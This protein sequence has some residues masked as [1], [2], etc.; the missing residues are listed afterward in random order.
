MLVIQRAIQGAG[1]K[2][3]KAARASSMACSARANSCARNSTPLQ[4]AVASPKQRASPDS[5]AS[6]TASSMSPWD[7]WR[8]ARIECVDQ[9]EE[10]AGM[11]VSCLGL[12]AFRGQSL[13]PEL[14]DRLQHREAWFVTI[15]RDVDPA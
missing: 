7:V 6:A 11:S 9:I 10:V 4:Y 3:A 14:A 13:Q 2:E 8:H 12:L 1:G 5:W 15:V